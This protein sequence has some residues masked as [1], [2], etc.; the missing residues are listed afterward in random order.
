MLDQKLKK[1]STVRVTLENQQVLAGRLL[2]CDEVMNAL[3]EETVEFKWNKKIKKWQKRKLGFCVIRGASVTSVS[4][5]R[6]SA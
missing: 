6:E 1:N 3:M 4:I 5:E 2:A